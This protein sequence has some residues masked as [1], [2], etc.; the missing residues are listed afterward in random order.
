[1]VCA[2]RSLFMSLAVRHLTV[3]VLNCAINNTPVFVSVV[4]QYNKAL[5]PKTEGFKEVVYEED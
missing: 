1:M 3:N 4:V 2:Y 5:G